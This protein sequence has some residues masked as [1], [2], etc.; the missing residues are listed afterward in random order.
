MFADVNGIRMCYEDRGEGEPVVLIGGFGAN[1]LFW[2]DAVSMMDGYRAITYDNR[3]VGDTEYSGGFS[4]D[5]LADDVV[6]LLDHLGIDRAHAVGWSMGSQI[7]QSLG[8][9]H[10][11]RLKS[12]TLVSAYRRFP[13]RSYYVLKGFNDLALNGDAPMACLAMA[14]NA[15]CFPEWMFRDMDDRGITFPIPERLERPEGLRDQ[16]DAIRG[17]DT[18]DA[19]RGIKVPTLVVHGGEDLMV[20]PEEGRKVADAVEGS[21]FLLLGSAGHSIPFG[22]CWTQLRAFIGSNA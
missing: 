6:A 21:R 22:E 11:D 16:L 18:T 19:A 15:F 14:V 1:R 8:I 2:D 13:F 20:A 17:Y 9:R 10:A 3:G 12:L 5:D 7:G 4:I